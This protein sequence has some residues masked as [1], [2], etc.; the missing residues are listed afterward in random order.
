MHIRKQPSASALDVALAEAGEDIAAAFGATSR[1][2]DDEMSFAEA[3]GAFYIEL[4][5]PV[6][7]DVDPK[8]ILLAA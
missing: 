3:A 1:D 8:A 7:S 6:D 4:G 2:D 5:L